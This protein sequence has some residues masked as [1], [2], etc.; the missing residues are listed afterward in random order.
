MRKTIKTNAIFGEFTP[1]DLQDCYNIYAISYADVGSDKPHTEVINTAANLSLSVVVKRFVNDKVKEILDGYSESR[2][3][4]P[5]LAENVKKMVEGIKTYK[6]DENGFWTEDVKKGGVRGAVQVFYAEGK[7]HLIKSGYAVDKSVYDGLISGVSEWISDNFGQEATVADSLSIVPFMDYE[8]HMLSERDFPGLYGMARQVGIS[9]D[10][11]DVSGRPVALIDFSKKEV[12]DLVSVQLGGK[13]GNFIE[14]ENTLVINETVTIAPPFIVTNSAGSNISSIMR[15]ILALLVDDVGFAQ[16]RLTEMIDSG[17]DREEAI[18]VVSVDRFE[19]MCR[20]ELGTGMASFGDLMYRTVSS[21]MSGEGWMPVTDD[22]NRKMV[23][24]ETEGEGVEK[25]LAAFSN[26]KKCFDAGNQANKSF[27]Y[28]VSVPSGFKLKNEKLFRKIFLFGGRLSDE[29][30]LLMSYFCLPS[31]ALA[32]F[33]YGQVDDIKEYDPTV[34]TLT[35]PMAFAMDDRRS[36]D[37]V[38]T[39]AEKSVEK[40][41]I[42]SKNGPTRDVSEYPGCVLSLKSIPMIY[43]ECKPMFDSRGVEFK[44]IPVILLMMPENRGVL[45]GYVSPRKVTESQ[46]AELMKQFAGFTP[47]LIMI[48][49]SAPGMD[50]D[51]VSDVI[52]HEVSHYID[53]LLV[54]DNKADPSIMNVNKVPETSLENAIA[55]IKSYLASPTE[56]KAHQMEVNIHLSKMNAEFVRKHRAIIMRKLMGLFVNQKEKYSVSRPYSKKDRFVEFNR[57]LDSSL[58]GR[59][60]TIHSG[61]DDVTG[62]T[63]K[64]LSVDGNKAKIDLPDDVELNVGAYMTPTISSDSYTEA[65]EEGYFTIINR[66]IDAILKNSEV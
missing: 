30:H 64:V 60:V 52:V 21:E 27:Y 35:M 12:A 40:Q 55:N 62:I 56:D 16:E 29:R 54:M 43:A 32:L 59:D 36:Q 14:R 37:D 10:Q 34:N 4:N 17:M 66:A 44:E 48:N 5:L 8:V 11:V 63:A 50:M 65:Q 53:D 13:T 61:G 38:V 1:V 33:G 24:L 46:G 6:Q 7:I 58:S 49:L 26:V 31:E 57:P 19:N 20:M 39:E 42:E 47:P 3:S 51:K 9:I 18:G 41:L 23:N 15:N 25:F 28:S 22:V 2:R 45:G